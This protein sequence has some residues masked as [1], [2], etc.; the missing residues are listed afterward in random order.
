MRHIGLVE[1]EAI[2][3][4]TTRVI[5]LTTDGITEFRVKY[6]EVGILQ[7]TNGTQTHTQG[8]TGVGGITV[9]RLT[10][11]HQVAIRELGIEVLGPFFIH[12][13]VIEDPYQVEAEAA[14]AKF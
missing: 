2:A 10:V 9:P 12:H 5:A 13:G 7:L 6:A 14:E 4:I 8:F 3:C 11:E 1:H